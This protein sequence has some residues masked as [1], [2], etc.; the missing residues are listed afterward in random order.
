MPSEPES[1]IGGKV[2]AAKRIPTQVQHVRDKIAGCP[3]AAESL[4]ARL[5]AQELNLLAT[6]FKNTMGPRVKTEY[7]KL[8]N[9][10]ARREWLAQ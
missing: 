10:A 6:S 3:V 9:D 8:G 2:R 1:P 5:S 7:K 4:K